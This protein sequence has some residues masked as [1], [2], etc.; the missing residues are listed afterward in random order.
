ML[1]TISA[2]SIVAVVLLAAAFTLNAQAPQAAKTGAPQAPAKPAAGVP[3]SLGSGAGA[4]ARE[5][6]FPP[7]DFKPPKPAEFRATL[8]NGLV[9]YIAEDHEIPWFEATLLSPV[10]GGG[11]GGGRGRGMGPDGEEEGGGRSALMRARST[12]RR[13]AAAAAAER[14]RSSS[15]RRSWA[16]RTCAAR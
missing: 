15:R 6:K 10:S 2:C 9:V 4:A 8:S 13:A 1:K 12:G 7:L 3:H 14:A 16:S 5:F 11:G